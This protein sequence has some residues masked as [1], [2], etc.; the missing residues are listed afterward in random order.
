MVSHE[1]HETYEDVFARVSADGILTDPEKIE[2]GIAWAE[3]K[4][5]NNELCGTV[6]HIRRVAHA[7]LSSVWVGRKADEHVRDIAG[8][9]T[10]PDPRQRIEALVMSS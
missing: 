7:S 9:K 10:N 4:A 1:R 6:S 2:L 8:T 5:S 3:V